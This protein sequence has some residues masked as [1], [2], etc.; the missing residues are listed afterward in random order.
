MREIQRKREREKCFGAGSELV[1]P[2]KGSCSKEINLESSI[3]L[4]SQRPTTLVTV[5]HVL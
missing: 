4:H 2:S 1:L 5:L 3:F